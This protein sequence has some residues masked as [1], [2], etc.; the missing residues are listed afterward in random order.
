MSE[1][2]PEI[3]Q[4]FHAV[5]HTEMLP[6]KWEECINLLP[7]Q[8]HAGILRYHRWEDRHRSLIGKLLLRKALQLSGV[9]SAVLGHIKTN[10]FGRP[11]LAIKGDFNISHSGN[12]VVC[13]S[14]SFC[15][16]GVDIEQIRAVSFDDFDNT[17]TR[18]QWRNIHA[19]PNSTKA[20]FRHWA[21]KESV[22]KADGMGLEIPLTELESDF[23]TC[24]YNNKE[25]FLTE[26]SFHEDYA[27]CLATSVAAPNIEIVEL[28]F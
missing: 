20:F 8:L 17:M 3:V 1:S 2:A 12:H 27:G 26:L 7:P 14:S 11:S 5:F 25:W 18:S 15:R 6:A 19:A 13:A 4:V 9:E 24:S 21:L 16:L 10:D 23:K 22:I 28:V